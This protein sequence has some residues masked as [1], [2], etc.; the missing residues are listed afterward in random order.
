MNKHR[1]PFYRVSSLVSA[2]DLQQPLTEAVDAK[3]NAFAAYFSLLGGPNDLDRCSLVMDE[4]EI[5]GQFWAI[6]YAGEESS[7]ET[8]RDVMGSIPLSMIVSANTSFFELADLF[9]RRPHPF[10]FIVDGT[11]VT[12]TVSYLD[13]YSRIGQLCLLALAFHLESSAEELCFV[14]AQQCWDTLSPGRRER[15]ENVF[16]QRQVSV[17]GMLTSPDNVRILKLLRCTRLPTKVR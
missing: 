3:M 9:A 1:N 13:L 2:S 17:H 12:G 7:D 4:S 11:E 5:V 15:A 6:D 14:R 16:S 10:I 8:V